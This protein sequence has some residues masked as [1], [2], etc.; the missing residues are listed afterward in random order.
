M[1]KKE[2][3]LRAFSE[4]KVAIKGS[5]ILSLLYSALNSTEDE[6]VSLA[7]TTRDM[8]ENYLTYLLTDIDIREEDTRLLYRE[9][10]IDVPFSN[11]VLLEIE[12]DGEMYHILPKER[13]DMWSEENALTYYAD[14]FCGVKSPMHS[15]RGDVL[16]MA[17]LQ[18][19]VENRDIIGEKLT[20]RD[21][22]EF[23]A[24]LD[25]ALFKVAMNAGLGSS[26]SICLRILD[27]YLGYMYD[28]LERAA[29]FRCRSGEYL[30][31]YF[32]ENVNLVRD[33]I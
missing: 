16:I 26:R 28:S 8:I 27:H 3:M 12:T 14:F 24:L 11:T 10:H 33:T 30:L 13:C 29:P 1:E 20:C 19:W 7:L 5:N 18:S 21:I 25:C 17:V 31:Q 23:A 4:D 2:R 6:E 9:G 15:Y 22:W 32:R